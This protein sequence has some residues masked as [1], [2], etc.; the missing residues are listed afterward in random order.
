MKAISES[1]LRS[2]LN[3]YCAGVLIFGHYRSHDINLQDVNLHYLHLCG[4]V[5]CYFIASKKRELRRVEGRRDIGRLREAQEVGQRERERK[6]EERQS[7][8]EHF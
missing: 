2:I 1:G 8:K 7:G 5:G 3:R 4:M 6:R